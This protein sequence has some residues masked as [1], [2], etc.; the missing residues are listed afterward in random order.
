MSVDG[1]TILEKIWNPNACFVNSKLATI[2]SS[3]FKNI[4]LQVG[5]GRP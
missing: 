2:H 1:K 5:G 4:F 3:P